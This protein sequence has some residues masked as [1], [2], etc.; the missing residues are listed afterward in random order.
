MEEQTTDHPLASPWEAWQAD[1]MT[2]RYKQLLAKWR[3]SLLEQWARGQF[4]NDPVANAQALGQ[5]ALL[6]D[7]RKLT[8]TEF[9]EALEGNDDDEE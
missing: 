3:Q 8:F 9:I 7:L 6:N 5:V 1:P 4:S 2:R